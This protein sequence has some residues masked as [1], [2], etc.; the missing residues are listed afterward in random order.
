MFGAWLA[1]NGKPKIRKGH[2]NHGANKAR[3][4]KHMRGNCSCTKIGPCP[5]PASASM[6][7]CC[8][9]QFGASS[10]DRDEKSVGQNDEAISKPLHSRTHDLDAIIISNRLPEGVRFLI[11]QFFD[12]QILK[13]RQGK[14][15]LEFQVSRQTNFQNRAF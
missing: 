14:Q 11:E 10:H 9:M 8:H 3:L 5:L 1:D 4:E 7:V 6:P 2:A 15:S 13:K 12:T